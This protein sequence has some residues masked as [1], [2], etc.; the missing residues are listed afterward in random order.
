[1]I[2]KT[3]LPEKGVLQITAQYGRDRNE[4]CSVDLLLVA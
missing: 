4:L 2:R 1:M 3:V